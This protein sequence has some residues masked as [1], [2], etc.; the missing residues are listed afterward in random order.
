MTP[1]FLQSVFLNCI[2]EYG[3]VESHSFYGT[4]SLAVKD[5]DLQ[6]SYS[7]CLRTDEGLLH[8]RNL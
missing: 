6:V 2:A 4:I 8:Y 5:L 3:L 7:K 1:P